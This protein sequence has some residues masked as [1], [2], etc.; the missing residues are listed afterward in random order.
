VY[1]V[2]TEQAGSSFI[3]KG[4]SSRSRILNGPL[5][6]H[7]LNFNLQKSFKGMFLNTEATGENGAGCTEQSGEI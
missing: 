1:A 4:S 5:E 2:T 7:S 6:T 3:Q